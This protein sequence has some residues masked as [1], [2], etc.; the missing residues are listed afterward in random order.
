[1]IK[2]ILILGDTTIFMEI[3]KG[4][5]IKEETNYFWKIT[6]I[7]DT[8]YS[9]IILTP[10]FDVSDDILN[11][12]N[13][14]EWTNECESIN[15]IILYTYKGSIT[16][17]DLEYVYDGVKDNFIRKCE[18]L[19]AM[20]VSLLWITYD[21]EPQILYEISLQDDH[22]WIE[23]DKMV[24]DTNLEELLLEFPAL[25]PE[26]IIDE[27][28]MHK[29]HELVAYDLIPAKRMRVMN[30]AKVVSQVMH[31]IKRDNVFEYRVN[32]DSM[33]YMSVRMLMKCFEDYGYTCDIVKDNSV[34]IRM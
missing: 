16:P 10:K 4:N 25:E 14:L 9:L 30:L 7:R 24:I 34:L 33:S 28:E 32:C 8:K 22:Q 21:E 18:E 31:K 2:T 23:L 26:P 13:S 20:N 15:Y 6:L 19:I 3:L 17:L 1:M 27:Y 5:S 11:I 29:L 12:F